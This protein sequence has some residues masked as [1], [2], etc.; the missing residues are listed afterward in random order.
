MNHT[1]DNYW[2]PKIASNK[3]WAVRD[4]LR[5]TR[6]FLFVICDCLVKDIRFYSAKPVKLFVCLRGSKFEEMHLK[7]RRG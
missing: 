5:H 7:L 1:Q 2:H 3:W 4:K 6:H